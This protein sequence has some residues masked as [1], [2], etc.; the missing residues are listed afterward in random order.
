M[1]GQMKGFIA[2]IMVSLLILGVVGT[3]M[4]TSTART[5][6][7]NYADIKVT[8]D[9]KAI[10]PKDV[11]GNAIEPFIIDG[12]TYLPVRGISS[13]LGLGVDWDQNTHT[14]KLTSGSQSGNQAVQAPSGVQQK[15]G[16]LKGC[17]VEIKKAQLTTNYSGEQS[18]VFTYVWKN[19]SQATTYAADLILPKAFQDG[20]ELSRTGVIDTSSEIYTVDDSEYTEIRPGTSFEVR[21]AFKLR[22]GTSL[23][24]LELH[25]GSPLA[26]GEKESIIY[27]AFNPSK[28]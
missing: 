8:L 2:G 16:N 11:N 25:D 9:G 28:A 14:V 12:T 21:V 23:I 5:A 6:T 20:I 24:E 26:I 3:A 13:A 22:N 7:L 1:K 10:T 17:Y 19:N 15:A 18:V 27:E 4:A